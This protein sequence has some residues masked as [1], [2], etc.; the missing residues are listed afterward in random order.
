MNQE[1]TIEV[2]ESYKLSDG[3]IIVFLKSHNGKLA[4]DI[5]LNSNDG[6][7]WMTKSFFHTYGHSEIENIMNREANNIFEYLLEGINHD[8]K[9][10]VGLFLSIEAK[11]I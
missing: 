4:D 10:I 5:V 3:R 8:E 1:E 9:P 7:K 2:I 11:L 6:K